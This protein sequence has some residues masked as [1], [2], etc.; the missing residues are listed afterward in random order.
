MLRIQKC[1]SKG[2]QCQKKGRKGWRKKILS[3]NFPQPVLI[4]IFYKVS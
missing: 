3:D 4:I 1:L 2:D